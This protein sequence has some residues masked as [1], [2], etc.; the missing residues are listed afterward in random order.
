[1]NS[2]YHFMKM[3]T[4]TILCLIICL[5]VSS[6]IYG[7]EIGEVIKKGK[8]G[9]LSAEN[10]DS[11]LQKS[12]EEIKGKLQ[13]YGPALVIENK[14]KN[15]P[16][17][18]IVEP[19]KEISKP[20][21]IKKEE[22]EE[23][24]PS[25]IERLISSRVAKEISSNLEQFG[26]N[27]FSTP[28]TL[29]TQDASFPVPDDYIVGPKDEINV[30]VWGRVNG[31]YNLIVSRDG[32]I[33]LPNIGNL[34]VASKT[35]SELRS[36]IKNEVNT[37]L[38][39]TDAN[40]SLGKLRSI[41]VYV[42][43]DVKNPGTY[44]VSAY[45]TIIHALF[46]AGGPSKLGSLRNIQ[47]R[48]NG[49]GRL[50]T[51][52]DLYDFLL[53]G[54]ISK[55]ENLKPGDVIF[56]PPIGKVVGIAGNVKRPAIYEFKAQM[57]IQE[58][59][60]LAGGILFSADPQRILVERYENNARKIVLDI[61][62]TEISD[63]KMK[64]MDG[65]L[66]KIF[67]VRD[68]EVNAIFLKGNVSYP[69]KYAHKSGMKISDIISN[70]DEILPETYFDYAVIE[71][72]NPPD[73]SPKIIPF[74]LGKVL[75]E[76]DEKENILLQPG[77]TI[78]IYNKWKFKDQP[79]VQIKGEV[80][81]PGT[82]NLIDDMKV[83]DL[84]LAAGDLTRN[85][86]IKKA[87][88][89]RHVKSGPSE[90]F[91]FNVAESMKDNSQENLLLKDKDTVVIHSDHEYSPDEAVFIEGDV[92]KPGK[93][94]YISNMT[95]KDAVFIAGNLLKSAYMADTEII[96][97]RI[98]D[99]TLLE[100]DKITINLDKALSEDKDHNIILEPYDVIFVKNIPDWG[101]YWYITFQGEVRSPGKYLII[102]GEKISDLIERAGGF[103]KNAYQKGAVFT[104]QSSKKRQQERIDS[105][106]EELEKETLR[107]SSQEGEISEKAAEAKMFSL[108]T[109]SILIDKLKK[110]KPSGRVIIN[111]KDIERLKSSAFDIA[112]EDGD[113][114]FIPMEPSTVSVVGQVNNPSDIIYRD[115]NDVSDYLDMVG[116]LT[117]NADEDFVSVIKADGTV[118]TSKGIFSDVYSYK[119][120]PG[121]S[122]VVPE[123]IVRYTSYEIFKDSTRILY[124][125]AVSIAAL[126][127]LF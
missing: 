123:K 8:S 81:N 38:V 45:S 82:Y 27:L 63:T 13:E 7:E 58:A 67:P 17:V 88:I 53:H 16:E 49:T 121:D 124:E 10:V 69:G 25:T 126:S 60:E 41:V 11:I 39:G 34:N 111:L 9:T 99:G 12:K 104:R 28:V 2:Y 76:K 97:R 112:L 117:R 74:N 20:E 33:N 68:E 42:V 127:F 85:A 103:T 71:R 100:T 48:R 94:P 55:D 92:N 3:K 73:N 54:N 4:L 120:E 72:L 95:V 50:V 65:D 98:V 29:L 31:S 18:E 107:I 87:E 106:L 32:T 75:F 118:V 37:K 64:L 24:K 15:L 105:I 44:A 19:V 36:F 89:I 115:G 14:E 109:K 30:Y 96:R 84:I 56:V 61:N 66:I 101:E 78:I 5:I 35:V 21:I 113:E 102:K 119:L 125:I 77:D 51:M 46:F 86:Y 59:I 6:S 83:K 62:L 47:L 1:M 70:K 116:G 93:Y 52:F 79:L 91:Y 114:L 57:T 22:E 80:R 26:Y 23:K 108:K 43:G 110:I 40:I 90:L 122:I